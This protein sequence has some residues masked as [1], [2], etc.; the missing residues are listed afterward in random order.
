VPELFN[1]RRFHLPPKF[2]NF[3]DNEHYEEATC[4]SRRLYTLKA[5]LDHPSDRF[6]NVYTPACEVSVEVTEDVK[7]MW[8]KII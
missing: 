7:R 8:N 4:S 3:I 6:R 2:L 1:E 5:I